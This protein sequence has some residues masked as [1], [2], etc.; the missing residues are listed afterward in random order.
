MRAI[1][2]GPIS[3][4]SDSTPQQMRKIIQTR[5]LALRSKV[6]AHMRMSQA[7]YKH[8][9][10]HRKRETPTFR[11]D[12]YAFI[13]KLPLA[14]TS[15]LS[16]ENIETSTYNKLQQRMTR[17]FCIM[18]VQ[19]HTITVDENEISNTISID[20]IA[21]APTVN[22]NDTT[23]Q[24]NA[25]QSEESSPFSNS[26]ESASEL[27]Q[28]LK[29]RVIPVKPNY[30]EQP[31]ETPQQ[32][33]I[34]TRLL[35]NTSPDNTESQPD[36]PKE[37]AH[38]ARNEYVIDNVIQHIGNRRNVKYVVRWYEY[39]PAD[40]TVEPPGHIPQHFITRY[41]R[42]RQKSTNQNLKPQPV[43]QNLRQNKF[44][45]N[46]I[47]QLQIPNNCIGKVQQKYSVKYESTTTTFY[48]PFYSYRPT[49]PRDSAS[50]TFAL[51]ASEAEKL[52]SAFST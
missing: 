18:S 45:N 19:P 39:K 4:K 9:Y 44:V 50:R 26:A 28:A 23:A 25:H 5:I 6:D 12:N 3:G 51:P 35:S 38:N 1:T 27:D 10:D 24:T 31:P 2:D 37:T 22:T 16:A 8:D 34:A 33:H 29:Q 11:V 41:W 32:Q 52:A 40:G 21:H 43:I 7:W 47:Y 15:Q 48:Q 42:N 17:P 13:D 49:G 36:K 14:K 20:R 30:E 46:Y